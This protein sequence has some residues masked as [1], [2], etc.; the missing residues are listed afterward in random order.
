MSNETLG[1]TTKGVAPLLNPKEDLMWKKECNSN[2]WFAICHAQSDGHV[3]N[4]MY[5]LMIYPL[6]TGAVMNACFSVTDETTGEYYGEDHFF[7]FDLVDIAD[8]RFSIKVPNGRMEGD[9][10]QMKLSACMENASVEVTM[11]PVGEVLY[12]GGAGLFSVC[13]INVHQYSIPKM[14]TEGTLTIGG[15]TFVIS[16]GQSWFDRQ[17]QQAPSG[18]SASAGRFR[19]AW[20]DI[21]LESGD[22]MSL[23]STED[24]QTGEEH[25]WAT[26][27]HAN[28]N[29]SVAT[30]EP[31]SAKRS[32]YWESPASK[33]KYPT[34]WVVDLPEFDTHL[35]VTASPKEQE[36]VS[37][38]INK[39]EAASKVSGTFMGA[40]AEGF[41]Y[42]ELVGDYTK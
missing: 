38:F 36:I 40:A 13:G 15:K 3:L 19:W 2:S 20:M 6:P 1:I 10:S 9:L 11:R 35:Q 16:G 30:M 24:M 33:Q 32:E 41:C 8:D 25:S 27:L 29:Q 28:G 17:W 42:I 31:L 23:W 7:P 26:I 5:H 14:L 21:N 18:M 34:H 37:E 4:F 22:C 12:N 39:Y